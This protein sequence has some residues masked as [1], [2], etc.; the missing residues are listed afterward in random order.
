MIDTEGRVLLYD[1][2]TQEWYKKYTFHIQFIQ[3]C[4]QCHIFAPEIVC[5]TH[6]YHYDPKT[7]VSEMYH[8]AGNRI[9]MTEPH[10]ERE[11]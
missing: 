6:F 8:S 10:F 5:Y 3:K 11:V 2:E 7:R 9:Y 1:P 4:L